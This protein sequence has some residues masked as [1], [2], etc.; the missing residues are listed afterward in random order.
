MHFFI[1][2]HPVLMMFLTNHISSDNILSFR[3]QSLLHAIPI[4][5]KRYLKLIS[6]VGDISD[7]VSNMCVNKLKSAILPANVNNSLTNTI[8]L[9]FKYTLFKS[10]DEINPN[11]FLNFKYKLSNINK[12]EYIIASKNNKLGLHLEKWTPILQLLK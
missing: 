1:L 2:Y 7:K 8:I 10:K 11:L 12:V 3:W 6:D 5:W 9:I 4:E